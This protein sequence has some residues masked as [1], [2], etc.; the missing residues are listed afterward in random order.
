MSFDPWVAAGM[1]TS[2]LIALGGPLVLAAW[3][4]RRLGASPRA[5]FIGAATF[6]LFQGV[7]RL[8][9]QIAVGLALK[10]RAAA[11]PMLSW[12]WLAVSA[13]TAGLFEET[14]RYVAYRFAW[15]DRSAVGGV[16]LGAGHGGIEAMLL[17]GLSIAGNLV[18]YVALGR[19]LTLGIPEA[20]LEL[21][22][23]QFAQL[24]P[25]LALAGGVERVSSMMV[26]CGLSLLVLQAFTRGSRWWLVAAIA[27]HAV[28]NLV[29]VG[30]TKQLG[31]GPGEAVIALFG[32]TALAWTVRWV[33][34]ERRGG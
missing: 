27:F 10:D 30:V 19:G 15:K 21:L 22:R 5:F 14:G 8:P 9:W 6:F 17:V 26:H 20:Q 4:W 2:A 7:L 34:A 18:V 33:R 28:S 25:W 16:M 13:L 1:A 31:V 12:A 32:L 11:D 3:L 24:T 23:A 29:G